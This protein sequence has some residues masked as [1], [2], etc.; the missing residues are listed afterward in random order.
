MQIR[1]DPELRDRIC[2]YQQKVIKQNR[3][4]IKFT[5]SEAARALILRGLER[6]KT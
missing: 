4:P 2:K 6:E 3:D 1:M 5:F